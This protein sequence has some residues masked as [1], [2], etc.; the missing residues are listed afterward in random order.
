MLAALRAR[1]LRLAVVSNFDGRLLPLLDALGLATRVDAV[2]PSSRRRGAPSPTPRIFHAALAR[3]GVAPAAT[4]HV[5][6][7]LST[8]VTRGVRAPDCAPC[9]WIGTDERRPLP[10]GVAVL[11]SLDRLPQL[12][13][14]R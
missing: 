8:D 6:D 10:A 1:G 7:D 3:L 12:A 14:A 4:L 9:S 5:G 13:D 2:V 11:R